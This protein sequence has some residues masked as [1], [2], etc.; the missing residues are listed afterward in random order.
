MK[1][2]IRLLA[3]LLLIAVGQLCAEATAIYV[4]QYDIGQNFNV[5]EV[6]RF[7]KDL[8][9]IGY[10]P[11][12]MAIIAIQC[13]ISFPE[14]TTLYKDSEGQYEAQF[15]GTDLQSKWRWYIGEMETNRYRL[16][17]YSK[18]NT[19]LPQINQ[20]LFDFYALFD[21]APG[22]YEILFDNILVTDSDLQEHQ[23][24][25]MSVA[26]T[27]LPTHLV[28]D[29]FEVQLRYDEEGNKIGDYESMD[30]GIYNSSQ[31]LGIQMDIVMSEG[32]RV[33]TEE[34]G[35]YRAGKW[36]YVLTDWEFAINEIAP[37]VYRLI[38]YSYQSSISGNIYPF[39]YYNGNIFY[40]KL[41]IVGE[42]AKYE[43]EIENVLIT[44]YLLREHS[45]DNVNCFV[46]VPA[47]E[48]D[49]QSITL[50]ASS[51]NLHIGDIW[52]LTA[53]V[54]PENA[55][56]KTVI[57]SSS[58]TSV[59]TIDQ[60]G[61]IT[62]VSVGN[63]TI[64]AA[65]GSVSASCEVSV[66]P[67]DQCVMP[68]I[69][70]DGRYAVIAG[71]EGATVHYTL[72]DGNPAVYTAPFDVECATKIEAWAE[73]DGYYDSQTAVYEVPSYYDGTTV[74]V[75]KAGQME[76]A[77]GWVEDKDAITEL[78]IAGS[79]NTVDAET[80]QL[81]DGLRFVDFGDSDVDP[82]FYFGNPH[83]AAVKWTIQP[84]M[85]SDRVFYTN[86][87]R[88]VYIASL[89]V[90][91]GISH[92]N[93]VVDGIASLIEL[94]EAEDFYCPIAFRAE[95]AYYT[96]TF[97]METAIDGGTQGWETLALPFSPSMIRHLGN[98]QVPAKGEIQPFAALGD[99][100]VDAKPFW[101]HSLDSQWQA[102]SEIE[103]YEPYVISMPNNAVYIDD[104]L[105]T[106]KV[107]FSAE[108][109]DFAVTEIPVRE[110]G[111]YRFAC[112]M[113]GIDASNVVAPV[114]ASMAGGQEANI[115]GLT[116][117]SAFVP[118]LRE[119]FPFEAY[120]TN[121]NGSPMSTPVRIA[122]L[123]SQV[124]GIVSTIVTD[125]LQRVYSLGSTIF[126]TVSQAQSAILYSIDGKLLRRISLHSGSNEI[127][128]VAPA[129]Y[130]LRL[131][132]RTYKIA[133]N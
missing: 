132:D 14:G 86:F 100:L 124:G 2:H 8:I 77:F 56:D 68:T 37:Q 108:D 63:A 116:E 27:I 104:Y 92:A 28:L 80:L 105:L 1:L 10:H 35:S 74:T 95:S 87:N 75:H 43:I 71:E 129:I 131:S 17:A 36:P 89:D 50:S 130:L 58:D 109:V 101:L 117:G 47:I 107:E 15:N 3:T 73:K 11:D 98:D 24:E 114:N 29:D 13:D 34:G 51:L 4:D 88:L 49:A 32:L 93:V 59:V 7:R 67:D 54:L 94:E 112:T 97:T 113:V 106:G 119:V 38:S 78:T 70:Y 20:C 84:V 111:N 76:T 42:A 127:T 45:L 22:E 103:A 46:T 48:I 121:A 60:N 62:A 61:L 72:D 39:E 41:D 118:G 99:N 82:D 33:A 65:C 66:S 69:S 55:N 40:L 18:N 12:G 81:L 96:R 6:G 57:W 83:L 79:V 126:V 110:S 26:L 30:I 64:T 115:G 23:L 122:E 52:E 102:A 9:P 120:L 90:M 16:L 133:T 21:S 91:N 123:G 53:T 5:L 125:P 31:I 44:D 128:D 85:L 25:D 19:P